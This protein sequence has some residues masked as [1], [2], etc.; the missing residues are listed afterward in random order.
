MTKELFVE[1]IKQI[2]LQQEHDIQVSR[3]LGKAFPSAFEANLMPDNRLLVSQLIKILETELE[4]LECKW[5][6]YFMYELNFG[7]MF[8]MGMVTDENHEVVDLSDV[9]KLWEFLNHKEIDKKTVTEEPEKYYYQHDETGVVCCIES[10][11]LPST[12]WYSITKEQYEMHGAQNNS[13]SE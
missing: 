3:H 9:G 12:R 10:P 7:R 6:E 11:K 13:N 1:T 8:K 2:Q 5:I 4:D